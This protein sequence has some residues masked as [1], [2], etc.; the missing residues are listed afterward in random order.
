MFLAL[1]ATIRACRLPVSL[2]DD[3]LSAF[4]QDITTHRYDTWASLLDYCRRSANPVGRLVLRIGGMDDPALDRSSDALCTALQLTNFWQDLDRDWQNGRLYV[5][6]DDVAAEGARTSDLDDRRM[7]EPWQ[8]VLRRVAGRTQLAFVAGRDVCDG[9]R[10]RLRYELRCTWLGGVRILERLDRIDLRRIRTQATPQRRRSPDALGVRWARWPR[11]R[12][13]DRRS[14]NKTMS[15]RATSFY[16]S[17]LALPADKR[18]AIVAVWDF[19]R[20]VDDAV[21]EP[22]DRDPA[23]ALAQWRSELARLY[24]GREPQTP[25]GKHLAPFIAAFAL[26]RSG[27]EDVIDGVAM[28][29]QCNRY[30]TFEAL[31]QYCLRVASAVG[32]ICVEIFGYR[33]LQ[34][35]DYAIDLGIALQLTNII[36]DVAPDLQRDRVYIPVED[37][38]R[39]GCTEDDLRAGV[40]TDKVRRLLA[41]QVERARRFYRKAETALPRHDERRLVAARIMGAIYFELLRSIERTGYDVFRHRVRVGRPRQAVIAAFTWLKVMAAFK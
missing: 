41:F 9:V 33:D 14:R 3:L 30:E 22:G 18:N 25:Q 27:F 1:G 36:R 26:P 29:L 28:D 13:G 10:G 11:A 21:D 20:A 7:T 12:P 17:F 4:R 16:Y 38:Q 23:S 24:D 35:R 34:T 31:R 2:F 40:V 19:C 37:L 6:L 32:L 8:R 15:G 39:F 5:P